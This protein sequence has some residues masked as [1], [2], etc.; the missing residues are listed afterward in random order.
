MIE[1]DSKPFSLGIKRKLFLV[2]LALIV[3]GFYTVA[4]ISGKTD[5]SSCAD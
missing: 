3:T 5:P 2:G 4:I 1:R